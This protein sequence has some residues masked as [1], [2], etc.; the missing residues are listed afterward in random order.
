MDEGIYLAYNNNH[1]II[2]TATLKNT[3]ED[4]SIKLYE[5]CINVVYDSRGTIYEIPNYCINEPYRYELEFEEKKTQE[6]EKVINVKIK[7]IN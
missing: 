2:L 3:I 1:F 4:S 5:S 6:K 7:D